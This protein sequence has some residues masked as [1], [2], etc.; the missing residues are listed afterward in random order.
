MTDP[1]LP[2]ELPLAAEMETDLSG[3]VREL[4]AEIRALRS[5]IGAATAA[6]GSD[7]ERLELRR[8]VQELVESL[9]EVEADN[10]ALRAENER[11]VA[12]PDAGAIT[13][14]PGHADA[15]YTT[16]L[17]ADHRSAALIEEN[18]RLR[19]SLA[20]VVAEEQEARSVLRS[21]DTSRAWKVVSLYWTLAR[22]LGRDRADPSRRRRP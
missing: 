18:E 3:A 6:G 16:P 4:T 13:C 19:E 5:E 22:R 11:L 9:D 15:A 7:R 12:A 1:R 2:R 8:I 20:R 14:A 10:E 21:I 17:V